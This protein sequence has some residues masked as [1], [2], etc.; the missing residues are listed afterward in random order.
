MMDK[1]IKTQDSFLGDTS[2]E[3]LFKLYKK[4]RECGI[5]R[6][7]EK[8]KTMMVSHRL[9]DIIKVQN[10]SSSEVKNLFWKFFNFPP[11]DEHLVFVSETF[12]KDNTVGVLKLKHQKHN[13]SGIIYSIVEC[14]LG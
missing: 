5:R 6:D 8:I 14:L 2:G 1:K 9:G 13:Q 11:I 4:F 7:F 12:M 3:T 10:S